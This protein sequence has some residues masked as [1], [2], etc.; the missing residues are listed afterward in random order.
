MTEIRNS[1]LKSKRNPFGKLNHL[2]FGIVS[3]FDI[4]ISDF[5]VND[6]G[7]E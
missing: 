6:G 7:L 3:D 2:N 5:S 4:W 1:K